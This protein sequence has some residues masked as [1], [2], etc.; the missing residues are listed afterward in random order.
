MVAATVADT[1][2]GIVS[3]VNDH[4]FILEGH[5]DWLN[6]SRY[7]KPAPLLPH[8]GVHVEVGLDKDG[9]VRTVAPIRRDEPTP[10]EALGRASVNADQTP[11]KC[12]DRGKTIPC[13]GFFNPTTAWSPNVLLHGKLYIPDPAQQTSQN[14]A[15]QYG[16][17][18]AAGTFEIPNSAFAG[19]ITGNP[20]N[21]WSV[22]MPPPEV[23][24][25]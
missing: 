22:R 10:P 25:P 16:V 6:L 19:Y 11:L 23:A 5:G 2:E 12:S 13:A 3:R 17:P 4:G 7:A 24:G 8:A 21:L 9:Y 14:P 20:G 18:L 15:N 1:I